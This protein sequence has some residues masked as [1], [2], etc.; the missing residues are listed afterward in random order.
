ML[1]KVNF[2]HNAAGCSWAVA[3]TL[4]ASRYSCLLEPE[5]PWNT[6]KTIIV[7][8]HIH[9]A[10]RVDRLTG[11]LIL[12]AQLLRD[13]GL[14]LAKQLGVQ[15]NV[16]GSVH[17]V[18]VTAKLSALMRCGERAGERA[19]GVFT[20]SRQRSRSTW[21]PGGRPARCEGVSML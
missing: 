8:Q 5:P 18:D 15:A 11:L 17:A 20:R 1:R 7:S 2:T 14:V 3:L 12:A 19:G 21:R 9:H 6:K 13:V 16:A 4:M 10:V